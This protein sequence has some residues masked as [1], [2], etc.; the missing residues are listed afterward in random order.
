MAIKKISI[1]FI[2]PIVILTSCIK[3]VDVK[4]TIQKEVVNFEFVSNNH[5]KFIIKDV[6]ISSFDDSKI[7]WVIDSIRRDAVLTKLSYGI[8]PEGFKE[9]VVAKKLKKGKEYCISIHGLGFRGG[10]VFKYDY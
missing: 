5:N 1:L 2:L 6:L 10:C 8:V 3:Y 7:V 4:V 9:S